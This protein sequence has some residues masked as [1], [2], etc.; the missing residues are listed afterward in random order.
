[1]AHR[2][3]LLLL[4]GAGARLRVLDLEMQLGERMIS[5]CGYMLGEALL[6]GACVAM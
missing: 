4:D 1:M 3:K 2:T 6:L 5:E